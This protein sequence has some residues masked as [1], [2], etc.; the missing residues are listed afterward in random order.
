MT[1]PNI[2]LV[3]A[4]NLMKSNVKAQDESL[5]SLIDTPF[6]AKS[7]QFMIEHANMLFEVDREKL[8]V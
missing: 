4:P 2:A 6:A 1:T 7:V 3:F 8:N 5:A